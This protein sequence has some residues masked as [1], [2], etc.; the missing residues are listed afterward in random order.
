MD[1]CGSQEIGISEMKRQILELKGRFWDSGIGKA[2]S[3]ISE[4][5]IP[6]F[7]NP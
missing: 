3:G 2:N 5:R 7:P 6:E 4:S 1:F